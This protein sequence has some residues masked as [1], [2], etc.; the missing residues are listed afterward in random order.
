MSNFFSSSRLFRDNVSFYLDA[1]YNEKEYGAYDFYTPG[2]GF[3][4]KEWVNVKNV[5]ARMTMKA[6]IFRLSR[7]L[8]S[9]SCMINLS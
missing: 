9:A 4:S 6:S 3:P 7:G 5:D 2:R 8:P 1:G